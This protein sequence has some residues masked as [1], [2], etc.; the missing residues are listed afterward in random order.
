VFFLRHYWNPL[1]ALLTSIFG[2]APFWARLLPLY[3]SG[4]VYYRLRSHLK[5]TP[6]WIAAAGLALVAALRL[7]HGWAL[8]FPI[9]GPYLVLAL[10]FYPTIRLHRWGQ[11]GDFSYGTY[12]Y[13]YPIQQLIMQHIGHPVSPWKLFALS[14]P[15]T[16]CCAAASWFLIERHFLHSLSKRPGHGYLAYASHHH[17]P[18]QDTAVLPGSFPP[19][20]RVADRGR[21]SS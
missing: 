5:F 17:P 15:V 12:L 18:E 1:T 7:P 20:E 6:L 16:L 13:G 19:T 8:L 3:L 11:N 9:V 10:A 2:Y 4:V 14:V 21:P